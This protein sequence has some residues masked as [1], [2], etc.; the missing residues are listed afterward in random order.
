MDYAKHLKSITTFEQLFE[1]RELLIRNYNKN[2]DLWYAGGN[3]PKSPYLD[4]TTNANFFL[5]RVEREIETLEYKGFRLS[6]I[7]IPKEIKKT[8][9]IDEINEAMAKGATKEEV[10]EMYGQLTKPKE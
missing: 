3:D 2:S 8:Y 10:W 6:S 7:E 5:K 9:T 4:E 1:F